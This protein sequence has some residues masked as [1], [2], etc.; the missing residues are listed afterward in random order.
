MTRNAWIR[1]ACPTLAL[2][3]AGCGAAAGGVARAPRPVATIVTPSGGPSCGLRAASIPARP[4]APPRTGSTVALAAEGGR[5]L[6]F[7]ADGDDGAVQ[8]FDVE[9][10]TA[11]GGATLDGRP[12]SLMF[13]PDGRLV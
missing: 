10:G 8:V 6:A 7:A 12:S 2:G 3:L 5:T 13:L 11:V 9:S 1:H 4:L